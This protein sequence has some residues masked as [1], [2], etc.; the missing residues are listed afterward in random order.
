MD[1]R[2]SSDWSGWDVD[3]FDDGQIKLLKDQK[4]IGPVMN[5]AALLDLLDEGV[6]DSVA[7]L[8][9]SI[10]DAYT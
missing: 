5:V 6:Q 1:S 8:I 9:D 10:T 3:W 7:K 4:S 2:P